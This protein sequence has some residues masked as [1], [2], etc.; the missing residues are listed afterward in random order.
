MDPSDRSKVFITCT[1]LEDLAI[2]L[3]VDLSNVDAFIALRRLDYI[4]RL[5]GRH[6]WKEGGGRD[7]DEAGRADLSFDTGC[8]NQIHIYRCIPLHGISVH[9]ASGSGILA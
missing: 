4:V 1:S 2:I 9:Y 6:V 5:F 8:V 3:W 7:R